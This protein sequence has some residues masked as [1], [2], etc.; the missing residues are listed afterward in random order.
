MP[1]LVIGMKNKAGFTLIEILVV[2]LIIG[3][4]VGFALL[5]F[6]DFGSKR[7]MV[8]AAEQFVNYVKFTQQAGILKTST[9]G[10]QLRENGYEVLQFQSPN[11]WQ[12]MP[13]NSVFHAQ[14][15]PNNA[16]IHFNAA[17]KTGPQIIINASGD[18]TTIQL[19]IGSKEQ[20]HIAIIIGKQ[21]GTVSL[22]LLDAP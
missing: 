22:Q 3:I 10:I 19:N 6:G 15:F 2:L 13:K 17:E 18:M 5:A 20:P 16:L 11:H 8:V 4:T 7:R 21:N 1:K 14:H 9:L 12:S